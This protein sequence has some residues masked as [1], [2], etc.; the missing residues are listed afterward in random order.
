MGHLVF[1]KL[2]FVRNV[3]YVRLSAYEQKAFPNFWANTWRGFKRD[4][5]SIVPYAGPPMITAYLIYLWGMKENARLK[6]KNPKDYE[7]DK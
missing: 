5:N 1:G 3:I 6:R 2:A 4:F 7:N